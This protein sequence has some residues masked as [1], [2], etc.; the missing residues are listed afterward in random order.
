MTTQVKQLRCAAYSRVS[1]DRQNPLSVEDQLRKC[2]Q[3][4]EHERWRVLEEHIYSDTAISGT[5]DNRPGLQ[6][7]LAALKQ[8]PCPFDILLVDDT[9]RLSRKAKDTLTI[10]ERL[11]F[12][13]VRLVAISQGIDSENEQAEVLMQV[14]GMVD[15]L[16]VKE[17][18]TKTR[19]GMEGAFRRGMHAGG[20]CFGYRNVPIEDPSRTDEHGRPVI[21]GV[22]LEVNEEQAAIVRRIFGLYSRGCGLKQIAKLLNDEH[23]PSPQPQAGRISQSWCPSSLRVILHNDRYRGVV[24]WGKTK[25]VRSADNGKKL[26]RPRAESEWVKQEIPEQRIVSEEM[27]AAVGERMALLQKVY[28]RNDRT[29]LMR[30]T[31]VR[32]PYMFSGLMKC[33]V[34]GANITVVSGRWLKR[35]DVVY[36]C[37]L[38]ANRGSAVCSNN[39][40]IRRN[41]LETQMLAGLQEKVL[42]PEVIEYTLQRFEEA[43]IEQMAGLDS[44]LEQMR[45]RKASLEKEIQNLTDRIATG[46]PSPSIMAAIVDRERELSRIA[47]HLLECSPDSLRIRLK[48]IRRF[49]E[50][51][52]KDLRCLLNFDPVTI[53]AEIAKHVRHI[54]LTPEGRTYRATGTWDLLGCG[55][56]D[57]AG[58]QS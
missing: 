41:V 16:Y 42:H 46:D 15:S 20:R 37:P 4:A 13:G 8:R 29:G 17:L 31:A 49:V 35:Q 53:R 5:T 28:G 24:I 30:A 40:R 12:A 50:T 55:S 32:S 52:M 10:Y 45:S 6:R 14:H 2:R 27:W 22:R 47:D 57:G 56:M 26:A 51:R 23:V 36:G 43:L 34:C 1:T 21:L 33:R 7:L 44:E 18:A 25:K 11:N 3:F 38:N 48:D 9:S 39:V 58:G 19:R 54:V